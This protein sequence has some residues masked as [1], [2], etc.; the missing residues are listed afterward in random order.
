MPANP[1]V[2]TEWLAERLGDPAVKL[3]DATWRMPSDPADPEADFE[4]A[5]IPGARFF[6]IDEIADRTTDLPH[7]APPAAQFAEQVGALGVGD[8]DTVVIYDQQGL[9]SAA[10]A[11]WTFR[12][13][14]ADE[15]YVLDGGL[16]KWR[17]EGRPVETG[18]AAKAEPATVTPQVRPELVRDVEDVRAGLEHRAQV[19]DARPAARF[20]GDAPEPRAGLR[21][22]HMPGAMN[23]P[24]G[25]L[26][27]GGRLK[28]PDQIRALV[29]A[30]GVDLGRPV[31]TTCG[32]GLT[33]AILALALARL[34]RWDTPVYDGSGTEWGGRADTPVVT[35]GA[36]APERPA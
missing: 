26:I 28:S 1:L 9:F 11:W 27:E 6:P 10:R 25:E 20:R 12:L 31:T 32:S 17:A 36:G 8:G 5:H 2:E 24:F 19:L 33:A 14:G 7:M 29:E 22:G 21:S 13:F 34:G 4:A 23:L 30:A 16:P 18:P 15:V 35:G 3:L